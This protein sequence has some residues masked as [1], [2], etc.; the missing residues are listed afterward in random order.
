MEQKGY[1]TFYKNMK[2]HYEKEFEVGKV[3]TI[4]GKLKFGN[5]GNG[6]HFCKRLEDTLRYYPAMEEEVVI[7]EVT[8]LGD[9]VEYEDEYNGYYDMYCTNMIRID[10]ILTRE[11]IIKMFL[12]LP[13]HQVERFIKSFRLTKEEIELFRIRYLG[14]REI[15]D[16]I[17]YYQEGKKD[18][19]EKRY[20]KV[21]LKEH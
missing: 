7:T 21:R 20:R 1:K 5:N 4:S 9:I 6:F 18:T 17:D 10:K 15:E 14:K 13:I 12:Q 16:A 2:N 11:E 8:S 19:Y 3:Y